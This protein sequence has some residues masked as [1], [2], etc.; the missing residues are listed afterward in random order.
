MVT[1]VV[2]SQGRRICILWKEE[3]QPETYIF[4]HW[5]CTDQ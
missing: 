1:E 5:V 2:I 3:N 4:D